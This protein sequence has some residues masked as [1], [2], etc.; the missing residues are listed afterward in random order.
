MITGTMKLK[1]I[2]KQ[3]PESF[4]VFRSN[5]FEYEE[6]EDFLEEVGP[7]TML[8]TLLYVRG[9]NQELFLY[10]L[11]H[12]VLKAEAE[13]QYL[14]EDFSPG[15][16]LDFYGNTICPLKF[17]FRD[18]L[19]DLERKH[20]EHYGISRK[21]YLEFGKMTNDTC[22]ESW[23]DPDPKRF[24]GLLF[25]KE[26]NEYLGLDF[27]KKMDGM[28]AGGYIQNMNPALKA[29]GLWDPEDIYTVY[30]VMAE[31]FMIDKKRLGSLPVPR[32]LE[33][34]LDPVYENNIIIFGKDRETI[35]NAMFLYLYKLYGEEGIRKFAGNVKHALHGSVMSKTAGS[36]RQEGGAI[37]LVSWF[38]AQTCVREEVE[39]IWPDDGAITLPMYMLV[40]KDEAENVKDIT[41]YI[42]GK[43]FAQACVKAYTPPMNGEVDAK[44]PPGAAFQWLGWDFIREHDIPALAEHCLDVFF[45]EWHR[46]HPGGVLCP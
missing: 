38:F 26:F 12:A 23:A 42:T 7:D 45:Q 35:S 15:E 3:Y 25:S 11:D 34:L 41:D 33:D 29:A 19:E 13:R 4:E 2:L 30:G 18:A 43:D 20:K 6:P 14:L 10:H 32:T 17:T 9:V 37:Y 39:I 1:E 24:P 27:Q 46:L 36:S 21:C 28:F 16:K 40:R 31:M 44:L 8:K 5:G 22:E